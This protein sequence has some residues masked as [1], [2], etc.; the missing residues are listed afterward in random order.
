MGALQAEQNA[1]AQAA[2]AELIAKNEDHVPIDIAK[3][4][5]IM[6]AQ[7]NREKLI[8]KNE[9]RAPIN[10]VKVQQLVQQSVEGNRWAGVAS[11]A[12]AKQESEEANGN[13]LSALW[14][15][16]MSAAG[17]VLSPKNV[18]GGGLLSVQGDGPPGF[19]IF[20]E[21]L[22]ILTTQAS[23]TINK[24]VTDL[25]HWAQVN[26]YQPANNAVTAIDNFQK[27]YYGKDAG[28]T[29]P[30]GAIAFM[31]HGPRQWLANQLGVDNNADNIWGLLQ[32]SLL[33][34]DHANITGPALDKI[35]AS[36]SAYSAYENEVKRLVKLQPDYKERAF[37]YNPDVYIDIS[38]DELR[39]IH[40]GGETS[41]KDKAWV[42]GIKLFTGM[43][44]YNFI[45]SYMEYPETW[46]VAGDEL[47]W[48]LRN[49][50]ISS[51]V[52]VSEDGEITISY[53]LTDQ[54][55]LIPDW[56]NRPF[57]YNV[58]CLV[59]GIPYHIYYGGNPDMAV[60]ARWER[61]IK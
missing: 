44:P 1:K 37:S 46:A 4:N 29:G 31:G 60:S 27:W 12:Q 41:K 9:D 14:S 55:D 30:Q 15:A 33:Q 56:K 23:E 59:L 19:N 49:A 53:E 58:A 38:N 6:Q 42:Q 2:K 25:K 34:S 54:L 52:N 13:L 3:V 57:A 17:S 47:T 26:I 21:W 8:A 5:Q 7:S 40:F 48:M 43:F 24:K 16:S 28:Y 39:S 35:I 36:K 50:T 51:E 18:G 32:L 45:N 20:P 61:T 22:R 10:E 11:V